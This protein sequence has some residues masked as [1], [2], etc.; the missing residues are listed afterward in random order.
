M[1]DSAI[2]VAVRSRPLLKN[3]AQ[4]SDTLSFEG[5][6]TVHLQKKTYTFDYVFRPGVTNE[7]VYN[8]VVAEKIRPIFEGYNVTI[9]AYGPTG[10]GKTYT[11]G[12]DYNPKTAFNSDIGIIPRGISE[13]FRVIES[14]KDSVEFLVKVSFLELYREEI[15]DLLQKT[16]TACNLREDAEGVRVINLTEVPVESVEEAFV[17]LEK[18]SSLRHTSATA[19]NVK[20]SRSHAIF[21]VYIE[22]TDKR[23]FNF[24]RSKFQLVDLAGSERMSSSK[25]AGLQVKEGNTT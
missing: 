8:A 15:F 10:S 21:S 22:Q 3:E 24:K 19:K 4:S 17:T 2:C 5:N 16:K 25:T 11:M 12:T 9:L 20:S 13:I 6:S 7:A 14:Q 23:T 18:G 1:A